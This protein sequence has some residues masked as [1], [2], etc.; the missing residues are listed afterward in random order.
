MRPSKNPESAVVDKEAENDQVAANT[1]NKSSPTHQSFPPEFEY[2][3]NLAATYPSM[4][5]PGNKSF[6]TS[7]QQQ[8][9]DQEREL[10]QHLQQIEPQ[11]QQLQQIE[12]QKQ[13]HLQQLQP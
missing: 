12:P 3:V 5:G 7:E 9:L 13:Q 6:L 4:N 1:G 2:G 11:K 10:Q 8:E